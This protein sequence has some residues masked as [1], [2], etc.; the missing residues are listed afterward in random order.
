MHSKRNYDF[1][2]FFAC[3]VLWNV[4]FRSSTVCLVSMMALSYLS[5]KRWDIN[6]SMFPSRCLIL[7]SCNETR[8]WSAVFIK[9]PHYKVLRTSVSWKRS[10]P[11]GK[12]VIHAFGNLFAKA[13]KNVARPLSETWAKFRTS[14]SVT[15]YEHTTL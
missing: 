4:M 8:I 14:L 6:V 1:L 5:R 13:A 11:L 15:L 2:L 7:S 3:C 10:P 12:E 9:I